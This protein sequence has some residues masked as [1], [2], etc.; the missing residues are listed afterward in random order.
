MAYKE[1]LSKMIKNSGVSLR[2]ISNRCKYFGVEVSSSYISQL[3]TG[4][5]PPATE[6]VNVA[7]ANVCDVE[8]AELVIEGYL[9]KAPEIIEHYILLSMKLNNQMLDLMANKF[10][11]G[12]TSEE[13]QSVNFI[14]KL[15]YNI[16]YFDILKKRMRQETEIDIKKL[17][18][19]KFAGKYRVESPIF[20]EDDSMNPIIPISSVI[21]YKNT[22]VKEWG[23]PSFEF[24]DNDIIVF[25]IRDDRTKKKYVRRY[26]K[27][28]KSIILLAENKKYQPIYLPEEDI[29]ILGKVT[30]YK[31][32]I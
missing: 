26:Y 17:V 31:V 13:I 5:L 16:H 24:K 10:E 8:A 18:G 11:T 1:V 32:I 27:N 21:E 2:E 25:I 19:S 7:L 23:K 6:E 30:G 4:K 20:M 12:V 3:Q 9:E 15:D 29:L 22:S 14:S 28:D